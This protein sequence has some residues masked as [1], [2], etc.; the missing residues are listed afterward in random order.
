MM[1]S[2]IV[3]LLVM[4][5]SS[6]SLLACDPPG[7]ENFYEVKH[8]LFGHIG[9]EILTLRCSDDK[10]MIDRKIHVTV[11]VLLMVAYRR[12]AH[13]T[14]TW[15]NDRLVRFEGYTN[16]NGQESRLLAHAAADGSMII[17]GPEGQIEVPQ[18]V[19]PTDPWNQSFIDRALQFDRIDG[20]LV[21]VAVTA[22]GEEE[23]EIEERLTRARKFL[24]SG[25]RKQ[26]FWFGL[27]GRWLKSRILHASGAITITRQRLNLRTQ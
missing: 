15:Q 17:D 8:E 12:D 27:D 26:E 2:L 22:A 3:F 10:I 7:E 1:R 25:E 9:Q 13:Y 14:E 24:L 5:T 6:A 23:I 11:R 19:I 16:D 4:I 18:A 20:D 21:T